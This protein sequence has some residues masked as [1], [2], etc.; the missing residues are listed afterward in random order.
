MRQKLPAAFSNGQFDANI[1]DPTNDL[2][3]QMANF[4]GKRY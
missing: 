2:F 1:A 3:A 4:D